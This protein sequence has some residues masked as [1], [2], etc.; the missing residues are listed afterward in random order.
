MPPTQLYDLDIV[1]F[2][3]DSI[4]DADR[5]RSSDGMGF[6]Y[7]SLVA[8]WFAALYPE[9]KVQFINRG[10]SGNRVKDLLA[11]WQADCLNLKP[12]WLSIGIGINDTWRRLDSNEPTSTEV[13]ERQYRSLLEQ[14]RKSLTVRLIL[15]EPFV[16]PVSS[17]QLEWRIDLDPK[18]HVIRKLAREFDALY[19]PMDG[20]FAQ[21]AARRELS[22]WAADGVHPTQAGH[23]LIAQNWLRSVGAI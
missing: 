4:T 10:I 7:A 11:R 14:T 6:G 20:L 19:L 3:G 21:A 13:F 5:A 16:L 17:G 15:I 1:L 8:S 9:R 18:I 2:Q 12:T 22:F 23:A